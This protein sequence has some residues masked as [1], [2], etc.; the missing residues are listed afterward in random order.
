M[1]IIFKI[2]VFT[3]MATTGIIGAV[4]LFEIIQSTLVVIIDSIRCAMVILQP[5]NESLQ[6]LNPDLISTLK[7][8]DQPKNSCL[9]NF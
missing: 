1:S 9:L 6:L 3:N 7:P 8:A 4:P 2:N 5:T